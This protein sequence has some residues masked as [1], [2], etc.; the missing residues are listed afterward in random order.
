MGTRFDGSQLHILLLSMTSFETRFQTP[1]MA[2]PTGMELTMLSGK[3]IR[4]QVR[5]RMYCAYDSGV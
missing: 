1:G 4:D 2:C 3:P 5:S